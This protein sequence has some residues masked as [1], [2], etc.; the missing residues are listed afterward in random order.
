M[1]NKIHKQT[2]VLH[3]L[4]KHACF[5][6]GLTIT[7]SIVVGVQNNSLRTVVLLHLLLCV[8]LVMKVVLL[9]FEVASFAFLFC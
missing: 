4:Q 9:A 8:C 3:G 7:I 1:R 6:A 5:G 2:L